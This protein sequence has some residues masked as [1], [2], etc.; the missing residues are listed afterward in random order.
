MTKLGI[1]GRKFGERAKAKGL[2]G[3]YTSINDVRAGR[4][5]N[6]SHEM[7]HSIAVVFGIAERR[8]LAAAGIPGHAEATFD[9]LLAVH[10][11][12]APD[13]QREGVK[14]YEAYQRS[15]QRLR[16]THQQVT[17]TSQ[18]VDMEDDEQL[19]RYLATHYQLDEVKINQMLQTLAEQQ[20]TGETD[21]DR[22]SSPGTP[23]RSGRRRVAR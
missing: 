19:T 11:R 18:P 12:L 10:K 14:V 8:V 23:K 5:A 4:H 15:V 22:V 17:V 13:E 16:R 7:A 3:N 2:T 20:P 1:S 6:I 9:R 21:R